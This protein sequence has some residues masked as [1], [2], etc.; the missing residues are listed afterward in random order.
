VTHS[1]EAAD[2]AASV[3]RAAFAF[4][5]LMWVGV[6]LMSVF[7]NIMLWLPSLIR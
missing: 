7:P 5:L 6:V 4:F 3:D 2:H 1:N